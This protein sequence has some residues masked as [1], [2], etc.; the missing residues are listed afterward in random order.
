MDE[1]GH[2]RPKGRPPK[3]CYWDPRPAEPSG[4]WRRNGTHEEYNPKAAERA[5]TAALRRTE[6][7]REQRR[8]HARLD[9]LLDEAMLLVQPASASSHYDRDESRDGSDSE[10]SESDSDDNS[11]HGA[12]EDYSHDIGP[13]THTVRR[14]LDKSRQKIGSMNRE[15]CY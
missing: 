9:T 8:A 7:T 10:V 11:Q 2:P 5:R 1:R 13:C 3:D 14:M 6:T 4:T 12:D 15:V